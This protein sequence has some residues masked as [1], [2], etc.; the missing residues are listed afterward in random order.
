MLKD[1]GRIERQLSMAQQK[2]SALEA[3]LATEGVTGK[4]R[5][6]NAVWRHL[7]ADY[8]QLKRRLNAVSALEAREADAAQRKSEKAS[9][10]TA[11]A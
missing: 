2:L 6:K 1:R 8:R 3:K 10:E 9:A 5:N 11:E 4:G 7:N